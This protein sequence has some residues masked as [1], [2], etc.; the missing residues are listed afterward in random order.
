M[1]K[2]G[3][4]IFKS[5]LNNFDIP[6]NNNKEA[7]KQSL[8]EGFKKEKKT[9]EEILVEGASLHTIPGNKFLLEYWN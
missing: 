5:F 7:L 8:L 2:E 6:L 3:N 4:P 9:A 1:E